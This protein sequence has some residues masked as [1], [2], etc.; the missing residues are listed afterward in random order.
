MSTTTIMKTPSKPTEAVPT[1]FG[2]AKLLIIDDEHLVATGMAATVT[3][4]GHT[5]LALGADG[6]Q[7]M[8]LARAHCP[9]MILMDIQMPKK[10]GIDAAKEIFAELAIP[11]IIISAYSDED[12]IRRIHAGGDVSGVYGYLLKPVNP[13]ELRVTLGIARQRASIDAQ[14]LGRIEQLERNLAQRRVV[15]Q[16]KWVLV[17]KHKLTEPA[18]HDKLQ[19]LARDRRKPLAEVAQS[20]VES[21]DLPK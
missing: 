10:S 11:S 9:D 20:V 6:E 19:K 21:G 13:D 3:Q 2:A 17:E 1:S 16:A 14:R 4:L 18:A 5:V 8:E 12:K 7:A 15:E